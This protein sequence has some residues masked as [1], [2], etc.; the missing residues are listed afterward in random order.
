MYLLPPYINPPT[1]A[2]TQ[3]INLTSSM[4][5]AQIKAEIDKIP[6]YIPYGVDV[7]LQLEDGTYSNLTEQLDI[8]GFFGG[9]NL[10]IEGETSDLTLRTTQAVILDFTGLGSNGIRLINCSCRVQLRAIKIMV[11]DTKIGLVLEKQIREAEIRSV[12]SHV[13]GTSSGGQAI[14]AN[15]GSQVDI[16]DTMVQGG[17]N[18]IAANHSRLRSFNCDSTGTNPI[19]G[20]LAVNNGMIAKAGAN[21]PSG[22][23]ADENA[24]A[25]STIG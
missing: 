14:L 2:S 18:G 12:Y 23:T 16:V 21:Q 25:N 11:D 24:T 20:L 4:T 5:S 8:T 1:A 10:L 19:Y 15:R 3:T 7:T 17:Q 13:A 6:K 9:G 22:S